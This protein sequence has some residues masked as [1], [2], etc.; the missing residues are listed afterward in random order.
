MR[1]R[2]TS[3][4]TATPRMA[5]RSPGGCKP[6]AFATGR[7]RHAHRAERSCR[8]ADWLD[9]TRVPRPC[10]GVGG[11][12]P[13]PSVGELRHLL[14]RGAYAPCAQQG[15]SAPST[16][17]DRR[18]Y[19]IGHLARRSPSALPSDGIIGRHRNREM[20]DRVTTSLLTLACERSILN[21]PSSRASGEWGMIADRAYTVLWRPLARSA[22]SMA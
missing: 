22:A 16:C 1:H 8:T 6:W 20:L 14:Q 21:W 7:S 19:R 15:Y 11:K 9:P 2:A 10:R 17:A 12:T 5:P 4:V 13:P 18:A 3:S